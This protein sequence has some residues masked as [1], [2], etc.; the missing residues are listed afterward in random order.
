MFAAKE[1]SRAFLNWRFAIAVA[2]SLGLQFWA[3]VNTYSLDPTPPSA[4]YPFFSTRMMHG[5]EELLD[6]R[7]LRRSLP[8]YRMPIRCSSTIFKVLRAIHSCACPTGVT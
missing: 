4:E 2:A 7:C 3:L 5:V 8:H 6:S 1:L